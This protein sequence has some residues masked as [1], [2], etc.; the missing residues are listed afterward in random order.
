MRM[1]ATPNMDGTISISTDY[2]TTES[3][4]LKGQEGDAKKAWYEPDMKPGT[5]F[6]TWHCVCLTLGGFFGAGWVVGEFLSP[7]W[8]IIL[9]IMILV[10][11]G[12]GGP[13][14]MRRFR[15]WRGDGGSDP[16]ISEPG[17]SDKGGF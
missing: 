4:P 1:S 5:V 2:G 15:E 16:A 14:I 3:T 13:I 9:A 10:G 11:C 17:K 8:Y 12:C 6:R 7:P